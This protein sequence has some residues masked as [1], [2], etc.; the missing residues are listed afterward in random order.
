MASRG[1]EA[2]LER[3]AVKIGDK[4]CGTY[5]GL[6]GTFAGFA[7]CCLRK[8]ELPGFHQ[9][10]LIVEAERNDRSLRLLLKGKRTSKKLTDM[11]DIA[12]ANMVAFP[13]T[14]GE[15]EWFIEVRSDK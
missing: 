12:L 8:K 15:A 4:I 2:G 9:K 13:E 3:I 1:K 14:G 10:D 7:D 5:Q 6:A 11:M